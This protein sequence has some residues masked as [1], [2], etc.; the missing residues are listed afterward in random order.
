MIQLLFG[1]L[2]LINGSKLATGTYFFKLIIS[3]ANGEKEIVQQ[4]TIQLI[5]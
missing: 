3:P 2:L 1:Q 5:K 4:K